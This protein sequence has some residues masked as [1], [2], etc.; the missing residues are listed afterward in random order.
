MLSVQT[1]YTCDGMGVSSR[2]WSWLQIKRDR[3]NNDRP[4]RVLNLYPLY[5]SQSGTLPIKLSGARDELV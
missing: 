3:R 4:A 2:D 1:K 5:L